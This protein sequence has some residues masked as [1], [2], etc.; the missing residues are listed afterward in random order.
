MLSREMVVRWC[1]G[2]AA[3]PAM[4]GRRGAAR[5]A[6]RSNSVMPGLW[7]LPALR[8]AAVPDA[9]LR[10]TVRHAIMQANYYVRVRAVSEDDVGAHCA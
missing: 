8:E 2:M 5:A 7:Q 1:C 6:R 4:H 10:M 3:A 9:E